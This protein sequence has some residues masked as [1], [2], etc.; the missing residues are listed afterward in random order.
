MPRVPGVI[1]D[2][3]SRSGFNDFRS[4]KRLAAAVRALEIV[5][6][7]RTGSCLLV[8]FA[9]YRGVLGSAVFRGKRG[10]ATDNQE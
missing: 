10:N 8:M 4:P 3:V 1:R 9:L 5:G 6:R 7:L 2:A